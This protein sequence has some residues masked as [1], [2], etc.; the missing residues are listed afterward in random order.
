MATSSSLKNVLKR[1]S[2]LR[3]LV[4]GDLMLD[5]YVWGRVRRISPEAPIPV[6]ETQREDARAGGAANVAMN[7]A[8]LGASVTCAGCVGSDEAGRILRAE[9]EARKIDC[10]GLVA[11][12]Q[13]P[14]TTKT[15]V[16]AHH[17]QVVRIDHEDSSVLSPSLVRSLERTVLPLVAAHDG[18]VLSDYNKGM[19]SSGLSEM[20]IG[21]AA[22]SGK[23]L[24]VDPKPQN[25]AHF[26]GATLITPNKSEAEGACKKAFRSEEDL[27]AGG[28]SLRD[29]YR[30]K[31]VL[32]TRG[33]EG[34][35]LFDP[36]GHTHVPTVAK[37]VFDVT[38]AG[39]TVIATATLALCAGAGFADAARISNI[40]A[41][42]SVE[43]V[44]AYAVSLA[45]LT[46]AMR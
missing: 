2:G 41:G 25:I 35:S 15:R 40:A 32:I 23:V 4:V 26:A 44:G 36:S 6:V 46:G 29:E 14:T 37:R 17:Q 33:E 20:I 1:F 45:E 21:A 9:L 28:F 18:V 12:R 10:R 13:R 22:E 27:L 11:T 5:R 39:D 24:T 34:M 31:A 43:N 19:L 30:F 3:I 16:I 7:L 38:G 8:A 42:I